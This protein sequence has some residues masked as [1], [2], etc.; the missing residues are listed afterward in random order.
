MRTIFSFEI[1]GITTIALF[2]AWIFAYLAYN[3]SWWLGAIGAR[4]PGL[5]AGVFIFSGWIKT[6]IIKAILPAWCLYFIFNLNKDNFVFFV[7]FTS[8]LYMC[9]YLHFDSKYAHRFER[10]RLWFSP[11]IILP[12]S[13]VAYHFLLA[14]LMRR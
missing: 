13:G 9:L 10:L 2:V 14:Y 8:S 12:V 3:I 6:H 4:L 1:V 11:P 7:L 5:W